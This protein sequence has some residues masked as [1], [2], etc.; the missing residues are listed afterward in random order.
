VE[1]PKPTIHPVTDIYGFAP[2]DSM[3]RPH[4]RYTP[5]EFDDGDARGGQAAMPP[6]DDQQRPR[7]VGRS[8]MPPPQ[9]GN[10]YG[11]NSSHSGL[12]PPS[13]PPMPYRPRDMP[14]DPVPARNGYP[15]S[16]QPVQQDRCHDPQYPPQPSDARASAEHVPPVRSDAGQPAPS[17]APADRLKTREDPWGFLFGSKGYT[18]LA[19]GDERPF[20]WDWKD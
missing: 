19:P 2:G 3:Y 16:P 18:T 14:R 12:R 5:R 20:W 17:H 1:V 7:A 13:P 8:E 15:E 11:G 9:S 4:L 6:V 10:V